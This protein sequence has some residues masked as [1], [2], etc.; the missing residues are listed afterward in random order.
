MYQDQVYQRCKVEANTIQNL[1]TLSLISPEEFAYA[2]MEESGFTAVVNGEVA[3]SK[4]L[5]PNAIDLPLYMN[6]KFVYIERHIGVE[7]DR[8][9][10]DQV[11]QRCKVETNTIQNLLTLSLISP[12]E[13]A[14][15]LMEESG[16]TAVVNGQVAPSKALKPNAIDLP[17]YMNTKFVYIERHIG[18]EIDRMY[19]DQVYQRCKVE[20]NT[21]QNLL[22]LSLISPEEFAYALMEE[23]GFTAVVNGQVAPSKALKPNAIDL[24]LYM[25][26]KFVYIERHIGVEID[27]MYQDQVYQR[28]KVEAN[29][30][31]NL[32]TLSLIS[33][34]EFAYALLEESGFTAVVNGQVAPSKALKPNAIDLPVYMNTKFVYI[35]RHIGVEIDRMYQ[36]QVYQLCKVETMQSKIYSHYPA[37][38]PKNSHTL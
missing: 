17:L 28:C 5:K 38:L 32:L 16:F 8:M 2:L 22:T 30:I 27:R 23:S 10:Q 26:T 29:T 37:S 20:A 24:P 13:F 12:E 18:V 4:A 19:Q 1:L 15:A 31:Q 3:P 11:Y 35:E 14:Y 34:E 36:D 33:P 6:T 9:Y 7:I 25:N 21:I